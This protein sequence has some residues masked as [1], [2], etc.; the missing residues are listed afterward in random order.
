LRT[1]LRPCQPPVDVL[2]DAV[3]AH[4]SAVRA[5]VEET[6]AQTDVSRIGHAAVVAGAR[7]VAPGNE[8]THELHLMGDKVHAVL[9]VVGD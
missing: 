9:V 8:V 6:V 5:N 4:Y 2:L 3:D 1:W 7:R